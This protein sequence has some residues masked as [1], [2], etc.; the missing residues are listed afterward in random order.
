MPWNLRVQLVGA[1]PEGLAQLFSIGVGHESVVKRHP[2][3]QTPQRGH[4]ARASGRDQVRL[5]RVR[6]PELAHAHD[7]ESDH[8]TLRVH[9]LHYGIVVG[10]LFVAGNFSFQAIERMLMA[11]PRA[12]GRWIQETIPTLPER[13]A[14][15]P[16]RIQQ[17]PAG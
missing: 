10:F 4:L 13:V 6:F 7:A 5:Q 1:A 16:W 9:P 17:T 2:E 14:A 3:D 12:G 15:G 11:L 8:V